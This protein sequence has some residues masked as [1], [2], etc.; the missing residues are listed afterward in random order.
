MFLC[1]LLPV[2]MHRDKHIHHTHAHLQ[3][4]KT[5]VTVVM[6]CTTTPC[7]SKIETNACESWP[8]VKLLHDH[9]SGSFDWIP[10]WLSLTW[11]ICATVLGLGLGSGVEVGG[12]VELSHW[13]AVRVITTL[14]FDI[15]TFLM[16]AKCCAGIPVSVCLCSRLSPS[17]PGL[18][19]HSCERQRVIKV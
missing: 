2:S 12:G 8:C 10:V 13:E 14:C 18:C 7:C 4:H 15:S 6:L 3:L 11:S 9:W 19:Q 5:D 1:S 16:G 17:C